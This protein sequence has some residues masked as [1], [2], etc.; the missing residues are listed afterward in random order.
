MDDA[1]FDQYLYGVIL[2][3]KYLDKRTAQALQVKPIVLPPWDAMYRMIR[4]PE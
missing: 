2:P 1:W 3:K 4:G